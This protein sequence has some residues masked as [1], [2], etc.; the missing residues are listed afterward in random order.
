MIDVRVQSG[1]FDAGSQLARLAERGGAAIAS[2]VVQVAAGEEVAAVVLEH[3]AAMAKAELTRIAEEAGR[4]WRLAGV[5][6]IHRHGRLAP[7][8]RILFAGVA[9]SAG[10]D[11]TEACAFLAEAVSR[12]APFWRREILAAGGSRWVRERS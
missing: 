9:A 5:I 4:R 10:P 2:L 1:D 6:L 7:A 3:Y 8:D 12:R 11:A